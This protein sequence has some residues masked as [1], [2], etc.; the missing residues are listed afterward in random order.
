MPLLLRF[1][2]AAILP[3]LPLPPRIDI[4]AYVTFF[5][6]RLR[7]IAPFV[8]LTPRRLIYRR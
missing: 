1:R 7:A 3:P 2:Y 4:A 6:I 8:M 5:M